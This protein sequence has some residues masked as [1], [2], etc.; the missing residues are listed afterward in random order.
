MDSGDSHGGLCPAPGG[1][2]GVC[3]GGLGGVHLPFGGAGRVRHDFGGGLVHGEVQGDGQVHR[4]PAALDAHEGLGGKDRLPVVVAHRLRTDL[5]GEQVHAL[6]DVLRP[7]EPEVDVHALRQLQPGQGVAAVPAPGDNAVL[8]P[9]VVPGQPPCLHDLAAHHHMDQQ[10]V[11]PRIRHD[12]KGEGQVSLILA[13]VLVPLAHGQAG[14]SGEVVL[15]DEGV[16]VGGRLRLGDQIVIERLCQ[17]PLPAVQL[18]PVPAAHRLIVTGE[19]V[20]FVDHQV[21][22]V[23]EGPERRLGSRQRHAVRE[24]GVE[25]PG[26]RQPLVIVFVDLAIV[27]GVHQ[28]PLHGIQTSGPLAGPPIAVLGDGPDVRRRLAVIVSGVLHILHVIAE[29]RLGADGEVGA[30]HIMLVSVLVHQHELVGLPA[31]AGGD[32]AVPVHLDRIHTDGALQT[33]LA[34]PLEVVALRVKFHAVLVHPVVE[35]GFLVGLS[36]IRLRRIRLDAGGLQNSGI[37]AGR[38]LSH[39]GGDGAVIG[40]DPLCLCRGGPGR[41]GD[42][43]AR[44][45]REGHGGDGHIRDLGEGAGV[46]RAAQG[47]HGSADIALPVGGGGR[48]LIAGQGAVCVPQLRHLDGRGLPGLQVGG[49]ALGGSV[50]QDGLR[51]RRPGGAGLCGG[52]LIAREVAVTVIDGQDIHLCRHAV[53]IGERLLRLGHLRRLRTG[54]ALREGSGDGGLLG[55]G[56]GEAHHGPVLVQH[57]LH[58]HGLVADALPGAGVRDLAVLLVRAGKLSRQGLLVHFRRPGGGAAGG[59]LH[60][61][62]AAVLEN[63]VNGL[64]GGGGGAVHRLKLAGGL[65]CGGLALRRFGHRLLVLHRDPACHGFSGR[66]LMARLA[67]ALLDDTALI[68]QH[69]GLGLDRRALH[70]R[71]LTLR[72]GPGDLG[73]DGGGPAVLAGGGLRGLGGKGR[74]TGQAHAHRSSQYQRQ[75]LVELPENLRH[76]VYHRSLP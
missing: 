38:D 48:D 67:A 29:A 34:Q 43:A 46:L 5:G 76:T 73:G 25:A 50:G 69:R 21:T 66:S 32:L 49:L 14:V 27:I 47:L 9:R 70:H 61:D 12:G 2:G 55:G 54:N 72:A 19:G 53:R 7:G 15:V 65:R 39:L 52:G 16:L 62:I 75:P 4:L 1:R 63:R 3:P 17:R 74:D 30:V 31:V 8:G 44:G 51:H 36:H 33:V 20:L 57:I 28:H 18:P 60:R 23:A 26:G 71:L 59:Q 45:L 41:G 35:I 64:S 22:A 24:V 13:G 68:V 11:A 58:R 56:G 6:A 40:G 37:L 42:S 10:V